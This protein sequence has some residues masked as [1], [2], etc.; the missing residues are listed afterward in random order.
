[1]CGIVASLQATGSVTCSLLGGLKLLAPRGTDSAGIVLVN[2]GTGDW[3]LEKVGERPAFKVLAA[4]LETHP[5]P[6]AQVGLGHVRWATRGEV[7]ERNA[8][9][10]LSPNGRFAIVH[11]GNVN[12]GALAR[13]RSALG[14]VS[15]RSDTDSEVLVASWA[16]RV[17]AAEEGGKEIDE[18]FFCA[19]LEEIE[20]T[21][22][23]VCLDREHPEQLFVGITGVGELYAAIGSAG[24]VVIASS[25]YVLFGIADEYVALAPG[26][27]LFSVGMTEVK[28][29]RHRFDPGVE[30]PSAEGF[31]HIMQ[32][33]LFHV[34]EAVRRV[35]DAYRAR[36]V[37]TCLGEVF[38]AERF[39]EIV[40]LACGTSLHA[41]EFLA[42]FFAQALGIPVRAIDATNVIDTPIMLYGKH[43]LVIAISQSGTTT[44][45]L[46]ALTDALRA[47]VTDDRSVTTLGVHNNPMGALTHLARYSLYTFT[48]E[49]RAT[50]STMA[51]FGQCA[52]LWLLLAAL[53]GDTDTAE[54]D[55][56]A[57]VPLL[58]TLRARSASIRA[59]ASG[60]KTAPA[61]KILALG[62]DVAIAA[63]GALKLE[64]V[65]Y[66]PSAALPA[67]RLK[68]GPLAL[69]PDRVV[70]L[71]LAPKL[72]HDPRF[73]RLAG[74]VHDVHTRHGQIVVFTNE[75]HSD[76]DREG[77][78]VYLLPEARSVFS[79]GLLFAYLLQTL[80]YELAR[81]LGRDHEID[82]PRHL[83]KTVTVQ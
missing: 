15:L 29:M 48:G 51:F 24:E 6:L 27:H 52:T 39:D 12:D 43:S 22:A 45:T 64:E 44:D 19:F 76:F 69:I 66:A 74:A 70:V 58:E 50:A 61:F 4:R 56:T 47:N 46:V 63:E 28:G 38:F 31:D 59:L 67:G 1:M 23:F 77:L 11:N 49:E 7:S 3:Y 25:P 2:P 36:S 10:H 72:T 65:V 34:P 41:A 82:V 18:A 32:A 73:D 30:P 60:L 57:L 5:A 79:Q 71:V 13:L 83:A 8:H 68:H 62:S 20:G 9:P 16:A 17:L 35:L 78:E 54:A 14:D 53:R 42:P 33:E 81:V 55:L 21:N 37:R 26:A 75:G 40:F 80:A